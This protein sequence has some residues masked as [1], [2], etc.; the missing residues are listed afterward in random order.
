MIKHVL[1]I[2]LV[3]FECSL[4]KPRHHHHQQNQHRQHTRNLNTDYDDDDTNTVNSGQNIYESTVVQ[5]EE[6][7][8]SVRHFRLEQKLELRCETHLKEFKFKKILFNRSLADL[9]SLLAANKLR[10][11]IDYDLL[12]EDAIQIKS[13]IVLDVLFTN[14]VFSLEMSELSISHAKYADS[15]HYYCVYGNSLNEYLVKSFLL[16]VFDGLYFVFLCF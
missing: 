10:S 9:G 6:T 8:N 15:G 13:E 3:V 4:A 5:D 11:Q 7:V 16:V 14:V 12:D 1:V 2:L